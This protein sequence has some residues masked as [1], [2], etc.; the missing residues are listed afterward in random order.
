MDN[1]ILLIMVAIGCITALNVVA[2]IKNI[3]GSLLMSSLA[4]IG[5]LVGYEVKVLKDKIIKKN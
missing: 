4:L 2:L 1:Q 3:N 5:G